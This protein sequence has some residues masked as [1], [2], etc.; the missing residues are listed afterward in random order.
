MITIYKYE[1]MR[2]LQKNRKI[3]LFNIIG[4]TSMVILIGLSM[5]YYIEKANYE[6]IIE[7][8]YG[9]RSFYKI[10]YDGEIPDL[11]QKIYSTNA[12]LKVKNAFDDLSK[13]SDFEFH[14]TD[15]QA[16]FF[17]NKNDVKYNEQFVDGYETGKDYNGDEYVA[18]KAIYADKLFFNDSNIV[19]AK[20]RIFAEHDYVFSNNNTMVPVVLGAE[21]AHYY[22]IG[23]I[24]PNANF[25]D[26][27]NITLIVIGLLTENSYFYDNNNEQVILNR[28]MIIPDVE[29]ASPN[30]CSDGF[31]VGAYSGTKLMNSRIVCIK[32]KEKQMISTVSKILN[33]NELYD[34]YLFDESGGAENILKKSKEF[35]SIGLLIA[36]IS[37]IVCTSMLV[38][39]AF[40]RIL[41][42]IKNYSI[43]IL[44]GIEKSKILFF[45]ILEVLIIFIPANL[46][47]FCVFSQMYSTGFDTGIFDKYI[48]IAIALTEMMVIII[49]TLITTYKIKSIN[50]SGIIRRKE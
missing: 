37:L 35:T 30:D 48:I 32:G 10:L 38:I 25:W 15:V 49:S 39:A 16:V 12:I 11:F 14:Y 2:I 13:E 8:S 40:S 44:I 17:M 9:N 41:Q 33:D 22:E 31:F 20:G 43:Y 26:E 24:I 50:L 47:S 34:F 36:V 18:L 3:V 5:S 1:I 7:D 45:S 4:F 29:V 42:E 46:I 23:D 28:Y 19:L 27:T 6:N 21:Y